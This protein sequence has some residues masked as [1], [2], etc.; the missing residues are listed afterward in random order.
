MTDMDRERQGRTRLKRDARRSCTE[1]IRF[2][3]RECEACWKCVEACPAGVFGKINVPFHK[4][5]KIV[6]REA[7]TGCRK[8]LRACDYGAIGPLT[9]KAE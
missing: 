1:F 6:N 2:D 7:C 4:H 3:R 9:E 8:C 5:A